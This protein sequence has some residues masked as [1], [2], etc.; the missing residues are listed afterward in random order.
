MLRT[1]FLATIVLSTAASAAAPP[2]PS[3]EKEAIRRLVE[4]L[5]DRDYRVRE[6]AALRLRE[7]P[8]RALPY[9]RQA[10]GHRNA[11][12]RHRALTLLSV[13]ENAILFAPRGITLSLRNQPLDAVLRALEKTA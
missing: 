1:C 2:A 6:L 12:V 4:Y 10:L 3:P 7:R 8:A 11:L 13:L 5:G 9:V